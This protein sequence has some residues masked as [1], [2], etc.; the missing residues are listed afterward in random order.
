MT[1]R[2][3]WSDKLVDE[4]EAIEQLIHEAS[5]LNRANGIIGRLERCITL[6]DY[7]ERHPIGERGLMRLLREDAVRWCM[8]QPEKKPEVSDA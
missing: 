7:L 3:E 4:F 6:A 5:M 8:A 2:F 1:E